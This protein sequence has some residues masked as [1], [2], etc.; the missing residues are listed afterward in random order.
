MHKELWIQLKRINLIILNH[1]ITTGKQMSQTTKLNFTKEL[2][3]IDAENIKQQSNTK[4]LTSLS[5]IHQE[6]E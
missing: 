4:S 1:E 6:Y 3:N 2:K 5:N